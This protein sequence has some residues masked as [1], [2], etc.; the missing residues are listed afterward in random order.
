MYTSF[1]E[2]SEVIFNK[3]GICLRH[4]IFVTFDGPLE[5]SWDA[6]FWWRNELVTVVIEAPGIW[7]PNFKTIPWLP[8]SD[9]LS[10]GSVD[11]DVMGSLRPVID[12]HRF[13]NKFDAKFL[14]SN[15]FNF[16]S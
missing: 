9:D 1:S 12:F 5:E 3:S 8:H 4:T 6:S 16:E 2:I 7:V 13:I 10:S 11:P 14:S 15:K